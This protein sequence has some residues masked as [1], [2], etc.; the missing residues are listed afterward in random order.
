MED[1]EKGVNVSTREV[2]LYIQQSWGYISMMFRVLPSNTEDVTTYVL[3]I[4]RCKQ[5]EFLES[6]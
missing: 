4:Q 6:V 1:G 5:N 2:C 3:C